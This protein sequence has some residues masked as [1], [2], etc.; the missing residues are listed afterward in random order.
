MKRQ[1]NSEIIDVVGLLKTYMS[2]WYYFVISVILCCG[3]A[4][5][6]AKMTK[7]VYK[8]VANVLISQEEDAGGLS[9]LGGLSGLFGSSGYVEDEVFVVSSHSVFKNVANDLGLYKNHVVKR[10]LLQKDFKYEKYPVELSFKDGIADTLRNAIEF[11]VRV[12]SDGD[13]SIEAYDI[14]EKQVI[15]EVEDKK[16]PLTLNTKYGDFTFDKT[17]YYQDGKKL[18][19]I[20]TLMGLDAIAENLAEEVSVGIASKK[21]NVIELSVQTADVKFGRDLLDDIVTKYN[22]RGVSE[23][24]L[25]GRR[26]AEFLKERIA[27]LESELTSTEAI[28]EEYKQNNGIVDVSSEAKYLMEKKGLLDEAIISAEATYEVLKIADDFFKNPQNKYSM[29][30]FSPELPGIDV[31]ITAYNELIA[32]RM[33]IET[34]AKGDNPA[35]KAID[36]QI[37]EM[38]ASV[39]KTIDGAVANASVRL[40]E[41]KKEESASNSKLSSIPTQEREYRVLRRQQEV[42]QQLYLFMLKRLEET[43]LLIANSVPKGVIVDEAYSLNKPVSM[44]KKVILLIAFLMGLILPMIYIHMRK[45]VRSKFETKDELEQMTRVPLL[46]EVCIDKSGKTVVVKQ[47]GSSTVSELFRLIRANLQ[48]I[49]SGREDKVV[50]MTSTVSGEGKTFISINLAASLAMLENKKVLL[51]GMDIRSPRLAEYLSINVSHGL[52]EYLSSEKI[53][54]DDIIIKEPIQKNLDIITAGPVPPNPSELLML[55]RVDELFAQ[56]RTKYDYIIVDSAPVGMVSDTFTLA[57]VSDVTI[58][59]CR[60]NYTSLRDVNFINNLYEENRLKKMSLVVN[61]TTSKKGYG[62]GYGEAYS[63]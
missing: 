24:S 59:V 21:S 44:S 13:V 60:A 55:D 47:K 32:K 36:A 27:L 7:P 42:K 6:Y 5:C 62:Y 15:A 11:D 30:P 1:N 4:F 33:E 23:K 12:S 3:L 22:E 18:R 34:N 43:E 41:L 28:I 25:K 53:S 52:T 51:V 63:E 40:N 50:L 14:A 2:K 54:L 49:M 46:G 8:V 19:T 37:E 57:R 9:S 20:I 39:K 58:Y 35:L 16:F 48:F 31:A 10:N 17:M 45:L 29:M 26:T 38:R 61:G 56:L